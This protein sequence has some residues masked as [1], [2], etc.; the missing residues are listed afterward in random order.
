M[1]HAE[2]HIDREYH[3]GNTFYI[4]PT[5]RDSQSRIVNITGATAIWILYSD[6]SAPFESAE[7]EKTTADGSV[8]LT[9]PANGEFEIEIEAG[10]TTGLG[11][12]G[13]RTW[14]HRCDL[15]DGTGDRSTIFHGEIPIYP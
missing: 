14:Y 3:A 4:R 9:N 11:E 10:D 5:V 6:P 13:G 12:E 7:V 15:I 1:P 8:R 2:V